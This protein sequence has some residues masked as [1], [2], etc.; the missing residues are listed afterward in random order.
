MHKIFVFKLLCY[1]DCVF[2]I[3]NITFF[4]QGFKKTCWKQ[5]NFGIDVDDLDVASLVWAQIL[6]VVVHVCEVHS[7]TAVLCFWDFDTEVVE[8]R[9]Q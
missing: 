9:R 5:S 2:H 8:A 1:F 6:E 7:D 4:H 3:F